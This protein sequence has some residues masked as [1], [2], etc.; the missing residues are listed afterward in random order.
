MGGGHV[1]SVFSPEVIYKVVTTDNDGDFNL[2]NG[3]I[4]YADCFRRYHV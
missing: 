2:S 3:H 1:S 4:T